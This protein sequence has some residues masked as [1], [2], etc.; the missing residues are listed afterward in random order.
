MQSPLANE[1]FHSFKKGCDIIAHRQYDDLAIRNAKCLTHTIEI[2]ACGW[3]FRW[4]GGI[5]LWLMN[6]SKP[7]RKE[8]KEGMVEA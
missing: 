5:D 2:C 1:H 4:H 6:P 8:Q 7:L 3:E